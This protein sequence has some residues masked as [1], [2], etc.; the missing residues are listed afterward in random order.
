[1]QE[2][3]FLLYRNKLF[4]LDVVCNQ[5]ETFRQTL[6]GVSCCWIDPGSDSMLALFVAR[7]QK[8]ANV[9]GR[10]HMTVV[11]MLLKFI[12][13]K[14]CFSQFSFIVSLVSRIEARAPSSDLRSLP[15]F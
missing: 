4:S 11:S 6:L 8:T 1:M 14:V 9:L 10:M 2:I 7:R 5:E 13:A 15:Q 12:W 3:I